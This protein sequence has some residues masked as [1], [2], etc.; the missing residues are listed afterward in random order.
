MTKLAQL[1]LEGDKDSIQKYRTL[2]YMLPLLC[3]MA[4]NLC[5][6]SVCIHMLTLDPLVCISPFTYLQTYKHNHY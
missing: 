2:K 1:D 3:Q 4:S 6:H 5:V